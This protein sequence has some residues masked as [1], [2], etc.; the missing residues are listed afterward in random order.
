MWAS[1]ASY[2]FQLH[3]MHFPEAD[4]TGWADSLV[5]GLI[6]SDSARIEGTV[7]VNQ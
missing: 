2:P 4:F 5:Q 3:W 6:R 7:L 1:H